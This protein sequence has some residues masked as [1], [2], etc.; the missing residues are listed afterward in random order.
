MFASEKAIDP[1]CT[2]RRAMS[3]G[4]RNEGWFSFFPAKRN[5]SFDF[6]G[7]LP[8]HHEERRPGRK[9]KRSFTMKNPLQQFLCSNLGEDVLRSAGLRVDNAKT[10]ARIKRQRLQ[11]NDGKADHHVSKGSLRL[12]SLPSISSDSPVSRWESCQKTVDCLSPPQRKPRR[13]SSD[14]VALPRSPCL[15][16]PSR[17]LSDKALHLHSFESPTLPVRRSS[18]TA[19]SLPKPPCWNGFDESPTSVRAGLDDLLCEALHEC[20]LHEEDE[21]FVA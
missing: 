15:S 2:C 1:E 12:A 14:D 19:C 17:S 4:R 3:W 16:S 21:E 9:I 8:P 5:R 10:H 11:A 20:D 6:R 7:Q 13:I 18:L